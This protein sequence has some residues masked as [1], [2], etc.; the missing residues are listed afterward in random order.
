MACGPM[1]DLAARVADRGVSSVFIYTREAHPGENYGHHTSMG[2][3]RSNA[4]AFLEHSNVRR[5]IL[6]DDLEGTA[7]HAFGLL[8]NMTWLLGRSGAIL[9]KADWTDAPDVE[10]AL[11]EALDF[12][13]RRRNEREPL[14]GFYSE[15]RSFRKRDRKGFDE[16]L[17]RAGPRAVREFAETYKSGKR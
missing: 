5:R 10:G 17:A 13:H 6:L 7:H 16:G 1:D 4:R 12:D 15:R 2:V 11:L 3:K 9:Y 8:P 14:Q